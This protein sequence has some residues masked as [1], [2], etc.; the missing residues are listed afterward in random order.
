MVWIIRCYSDD[1]RCIFAK[2]CCCAILCLTEI[3]EL[4]GL[5]VPY[6]VRS[7]VWGNGLYTPYIGCIWLNFNESIKRADSQT[8]VVVVLEKGEVSREAEACLSQEGY[9]ADCG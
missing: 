9:Q 7:A 4:I 6:N 1:S 5:G 3:D 2:R 8:V